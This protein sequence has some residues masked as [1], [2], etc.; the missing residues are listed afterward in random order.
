MGVTVINLLAASKIEGAPSQP[1]LSKM[2]RD[3]AKFP[4]LRETDKGWRVDTDDPSWGE[5]LERR[6][7]KPASPAVPE[8]VPRPGKPKAEAGTGG[9]KAPE[10]TAQIPAGTPGKAGKSR[11]N[12]LYDFQ[13]RQKAERAEIDKKKAALQL[14]IMEGRYVEKTRMIYLMGYFQRAVN[15]GLEDIRRGENNNRAIGAVCDKL[16][17]HIAK[18]VK[19]LEKEEGLIIPGGKSA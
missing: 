5:Y 3:S 8:I 13:L 14:G 6:Q 9:E 10:Q 2:T 1:Y 7:A 16:K 11:I 12:E 19:I 18:Y 4:F 15:E 17:K